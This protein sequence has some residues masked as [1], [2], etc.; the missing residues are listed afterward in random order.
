MIGV[1]R[2]WHEFEYA[3]QTVRYRDSWSDVVGKLATAVLLAG[4]VSVPVLVALGRAPHWAWI[5]F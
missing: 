3:G 4:V 1:V 2:R 5:L